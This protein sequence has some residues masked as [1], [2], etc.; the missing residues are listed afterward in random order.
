MSTTYMKLVSQGPKR[1]LMRPEHLEQGVTLCGCVV[2]QVLGWRRI[3]MLEGDECA[4]C[5][6]LSFCASIHGPSTAATPI[7]QARG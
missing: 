1:H 4:K 3:S 7:A 6:E 5:A 2:T